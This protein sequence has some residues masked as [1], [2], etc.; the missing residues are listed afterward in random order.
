M[1]RAAGRRMEAAVVSGG[2]GKYE[3]TAMRR[4]NGL[5]LP[6]GTPGTPEHAKNEFDDW[7]R[8]CPEADLCIGRRFVGAWHPLVIGGSE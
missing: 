1:Q 8:E 3:W 4:V 2:H 5:W 7:A 6:V